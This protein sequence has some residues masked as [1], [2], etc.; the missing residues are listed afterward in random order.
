MDEDFHLEYEMTVTERKIALTTDSLM[1]TPWKPMTNF[2]EGGGIY[3][4]F[5]APCVLESYPI[6]VS[7]STRTWETQ[8]EL[9]PLIVSLA[10]GAGM[11]RVFAGYESGW[12]WF[13]ELKMI[14][15]YLSR[16]AL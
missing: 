1:K 16:K 10:V 13:H 14:E 9:A 12:Q 5:L 11:R 8:I 7:V 6:E 15:N 3:A 2:G 4:P